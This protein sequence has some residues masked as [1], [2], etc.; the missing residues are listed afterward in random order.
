MIYYCII[1][2]FIAISMNCKQLDDIVECN[3]MNLTQYQL[4]KMSLHE[5]EK[6]VI[7]FLFYLNKKKKTLSN[8]FSI[9]F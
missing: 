7:K 9:Y 1:L 8:G 4:D 3:S 5:Q 2:F 6:L